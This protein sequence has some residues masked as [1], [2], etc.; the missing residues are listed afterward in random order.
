[1]KVSKIS[2]MSVVALMA[3]IIVTSQTYAFGG[4]GSHREMTQERF[5]EMR[6]LFLN[7]DFESF[8]KVMEEKRQSYMEDRQT[9]QDSITREVISIDNGVEMTLTSTDPEVVVRLQSREERA[10]R[11]SEVT[12]VKENITN[13]IKI[14]ITSDNEELVKNIQSGKEKMSA[15]GR[16]GRGGRG[17]VSKLGRGQWKGEKEGNIQ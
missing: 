1:M 7:N 9:S 12:R 11:N 15:R 2:F 4:K 6:Q 16:M 5:E 17:F 10:P 13:G 14:T 8:K 3:M